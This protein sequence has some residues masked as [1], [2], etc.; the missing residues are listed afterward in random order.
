[1]R[2]TRKT[3]T[4]KG[5]PA[6]FE[7]RL[8]VQ[9]HHTTRYSLSLLGPVEPI[10]YG[11]QC[12]SWAGG[13]PFW[14]GRR[15]GRTPPNVEML[16]RTKIPQNIGIITGPRVMRTREAEPSPDRLH[17]YILQASVYAALAASVVQGKLLR[18]CTSYPAMIL[19]LCKPSR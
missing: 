11:Y 3:C 5:V 1:M 18:F 14:Q 7:D 17:A 2:C 16:P 4:S 8:W 6:A 19:D 13:G 10:R 9:R 12:F 15:R